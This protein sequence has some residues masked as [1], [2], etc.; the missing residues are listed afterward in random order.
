[1]ED[2]VFILGKGRKGKWNDEQLLSYILLLGGGSLPAEPLLGGDNKEA[3]LKLYCNYL[4]QM[5]LL[6]LIV[7]V[8]F[9]VHLR[10][11]FNPQK[12]L[13]E[14]FIFNFNN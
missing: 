13:S 8:S 5:V 1:M 6:S 9:L 3:T 12:R 10:I 7:D 4:Y 11:A 2:I 14:C